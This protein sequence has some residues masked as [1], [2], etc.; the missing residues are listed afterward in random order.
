MH[1]MT[2]C[3][4]TGDVLSAIHA[5]VFALRAMDGR[6]GG[7]GITAEDLRT[8]HPRLDTAKPLAHPGG[9]K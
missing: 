2:E 6:N 1:T 8:A 7:K 4:H 3:A 5:T 9:K